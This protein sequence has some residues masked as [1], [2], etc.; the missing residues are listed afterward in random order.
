MSKRN[1]I[2]AAALAAVLSGTALT[3]C[4]PYVGQD[5]SAP[6]V[7]G[8]AVVDPAFA[9]NTGYAPTMDTLPSN[10]LGCTAPYP[11]VD[12]TWANGVVPGLC[13][14]NNVAN[15]MPTVCPVYCFP[16]RQGPAFAPLYTGTLG[17]TYKCASTTDPRCNTA[18]EY[19]YRLPSAWIIPNVPP[20][21]V[22]FPEGDF[23]FSR[24]TILFNKLMNGATIQ[25]SPDS[26]VAASTVKIYAISPAA[27]SGLGTDVTADWAVQ[28]VPNSAVGF[29]GGSLIAVPLLPTPGELEADTK[30]TIVADVKDW[31]GNAVQVNATVLT[32]GL[33]AVSAP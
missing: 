22:A 15:Y 23:A 24:I 11:E 30:Y 20:G 4:D 13:D 6:T 2:I 14:P 28:Y 19:V 25:A 18:G 31:E 33:A 7:I 5:T 8:V 1:A 3:G 26:E 29:W 32:T 21:I 12:Q 9:S 17:G 27:S 16:P 10:P